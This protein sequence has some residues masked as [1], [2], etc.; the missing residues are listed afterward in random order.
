MLPTT[1]STITQAICPENFSKACSTA[2]RSLYGSARVNWV[3]SSGTP[4][5]PGMP[6]VVPHARARAANDDRRRTAYR[7]KGTHR[8]IDTAGDKFFGAF[9]QQAGFFEAA[10]HDRKP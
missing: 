7:A 4:A 8:G 10:R 6:S 3:T 1:G 9:L 5:E 2:A